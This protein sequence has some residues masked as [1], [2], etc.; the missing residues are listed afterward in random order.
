[1]FCKD[2]LPCVLA[3]G[4]SL[5]LL[6]AQDCHAQD[7]QQDHSC[8]VDGAGIFAIPQGNDGQN[9]DKAGWGFQAGAGFA[10]TATLSRHPGWQWFI[11]SNYLFDR[12]RANAHSLAE[13][14]TA[15]PQLQGATAAHGDFSAVTLDI[16][17]RLE[18]TQR[19]NFY[20]VG[21]FGWLRRGI[22]FNGANPGT[23]LQSSGPSLDRLSSNSGVFD[24]GMGLS[25]GPRV[26]HGLMLFGEARVYHGLAINSGST[27][28]PISFGVR[29]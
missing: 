16:E 8:T 22:G 26:F 19:R 5:C 3:F 23:L 18:A 21:G 28:V 13:A 10:V 17:P 4:L 11:T 24:L 6:S 12:F 7:R 1:M 14:V 25:S 9:F 2:F 20:A 29:W 27:L 15:N